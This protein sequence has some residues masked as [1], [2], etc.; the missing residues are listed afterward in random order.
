MNAPAGLPVDQR[1]PDDVLDFLARTR[2]PRRRATR[3]LTD[4]L[5]RLAVGDPPLD[6]VRAAWVFGSWARGAATVGDID[7]IVEVD[8]ARD[9]GR[10]ALDAYYRRAHPYAE[11]VAA[12]GCGGSSMV[13]I[14]VQPVFEPDPQPVSP[15]RLVRLK[16]AAEPVTEMAVPELAPT[17]HVVTGDLFDPQPDLVWVR[18]DSVEDIAAQLRRFPEVTC[19]RREE[20]TTTV[21]VVDDLLER[22]G[23]ATAFLLAV[24]I[25]AGN[26][27][28]RAH[29]VHEHPP[30]DWVAD[31]LT[32]R[33]TSGSTRARALGSV[34]ALLEADG[35]D[36]GM[37]MLPGGG[38]VAGLADRRSAH[39]MPDAAG[40]TIDF[41]AFAIYQCA[42]GDL[43]TGDRHLHIWPTG[44]AG[45]WL[46]L[47]IT[48]LDGDAARALYHEITF[49][50][51]GYARMRKALGLPPLRR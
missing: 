33:Y 10:Q 39:G 47:A 36:I 8:E 34:L 24:Q 7:L 18:G 11:I 2:T 32:R 37:V 20:R 28:V 35:V 21:A 38:S 51:N 30:P 23:V 15:W 25:R 46:A 31:G 42:A 50:E 16:D 43:G 17:R 6:R 13:A 27:A 12:M 1:A 22:L 49:R 19:A 40:V 41:N 14:T 48:S 9:P 29:L 45:P 26:M 3:K 4:V 44:K 5:G